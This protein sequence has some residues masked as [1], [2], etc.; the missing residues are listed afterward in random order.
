MKTLL[1]YSRPG[2]DLCDELEDQLY[3]HFS[4]HFSLDW[5]DVD[6]QD[7]SRQQWGDKIPVLLT[8]DGQLLCSGQL[9][10]TSVAAYLA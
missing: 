9:D 2:C 7:D 5:R 3:A 1:L 8:E 10:K 6:R 4:G